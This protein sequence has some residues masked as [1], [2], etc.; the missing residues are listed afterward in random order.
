MLAVGCYE[1]PDYSG[2]RFKCDDQHACPGGQPCIDGLC[3]GSGGGSD[4]MIDAPPPAVGVACGA[5]TCGASQK[6]CADLLA[7]PSCIPQSATCAGVAATCDGTEDCAG[8]ACCESGG[9]VAACGTSPTCPN[10][11]ICREN[12][13]CTNPAQRLCCTVPGTMEPWGRCFTACP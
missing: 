12:A 11:T 13:D 1:A 4:A 7:G 3:G 9:G 2:T 5:M 10:Q 8:N 6:C